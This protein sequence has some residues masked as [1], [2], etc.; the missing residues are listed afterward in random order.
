MDGLIGE[1]LK[2]LLIVFTTLLTTWTKDFFEKKRRGDKY[3]EL[4]YK[5]RIQLYRDLWTQYVKVTR[6]IGTKTGSLSV[7]GLRKAK[8]EVES[9]KLQ[10]A[11]TDVLPIGTTDSSEGED[12]QNLLFDIDAF[13]AFAR[14]AYILLDSDT[15]GALEAAINVIEGKV[16]EK[17]VLINWGDLHNCS[18]ELHNAIRRELGIDKLRRMEKIFSSA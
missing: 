1:S 15:A 11:L 13:I 16:N 9:R 2:V 10:R 7:L 17:E 14:G 3:K 8:D 6:S 5:E 12:I 18:E 4:L